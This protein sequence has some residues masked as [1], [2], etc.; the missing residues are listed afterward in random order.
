[1]TADPY[2]AEVRRRFAEPRHAGRVE[3]G[4]MARRR[5]PDADIEVS[6]TIESGTI[7]AMRFRARGCPH[8]IAACDL[9]CERLS[10]Q[11]VASLHEPLAISVGG[12]LGVPTEKTGR[13]LV[14]EDVFRDLSSR[15]KEHE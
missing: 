9:A 4:F 13:I 5:A 1:M 6:A 12:P 15:I 11:P 3:G 8:T 2:N 14:L 10:G 7:R